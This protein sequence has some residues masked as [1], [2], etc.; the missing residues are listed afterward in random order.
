[1]NSQFIP[2]DGA[3]LKERVLAAIEQ[4]GGLSIT[5][6]MYVFPDERKDSL[7]RAAS[8][9]VRDEQIIA[10]KN[11][12]PIR[13]QS[14]EETDKKQIESRGLHTELQILYDQMESALTR[15]LVTSDFNM[16]KFEGI[17]ALAIG[18]GMMSGANPWHR[19][20]AKK[21]IRVASKHTARFA[22]LLHLYEELIDH[23]NISV[24]SYMIP[25]LQDVVEK[26][27]PKRAE[28]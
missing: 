27:R 26:L 25:I 14:I 1:M 24:P 12:S 8:K 20:E 3:P 9:L 11:V 21:F 18:H 19:E 23:S 16:G 6:L 17:I 4:K 5:E 2:K 13:Y 15:L 28:L 22:Q 7:Y 10:N